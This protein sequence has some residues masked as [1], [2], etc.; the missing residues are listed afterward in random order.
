MATIIYYYI[1][2]NKIYDM[3]YV[4]DKSLYDFQYGLYPRND[5]IYANHNGNKINKDQVI[6]DLQAIV[7]NKSKYQVNSFDKL[8]IKL[9]ETF[10]I[11]K[12][13]L[14]NKVIKYKEPCRVWQV[15]MNMSFG[16]NIKKHGGNKWWRVLI[17]Q[18]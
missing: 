8:F 14:I 11:T 15:I 6:M 10:G 5:F 4:V 9:L 18:K 13:E 12:E 7:K 2:D 3:S 1:K 16:N 17:N